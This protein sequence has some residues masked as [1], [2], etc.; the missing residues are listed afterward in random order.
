MASTTPLPDPVGEA[1][2][3]SHDEPVTWGSPL[4]PELP[5]AHVDVEPAPP[6]P[7]P[8]IGT[9]PVP[10]ASS[11]PKVV[12]EETINDAAE[13]TVN[14]ALF[15]I[16][17]LQQLIPDITGW[18]EEQASAVNKAISALETAL[19]GREA[20]AE[21]F[22]ALRETV[23]SA[24]RQNRDIDVMVALTDRAKE[25]EDL[26]DAHDQ[27]SRGVREAL[28]AIKPAAVNYV[29]EVKRKPAR[30]RSTTSRAKAKTASS[31]R[32][33]SAASET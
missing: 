7:E 27:Y 30:R 8:S 12:E 11:L 21:P 17:R 10:V 4:A 18:S 25:I 9:A 32:S 2:V 3:F 26:L 29:A 31:E 28:I 19:T 13:N 6:Q 22:A 23:K 14:I 20:D 5:P 16:T 24:I 33:E 15:H 1:D